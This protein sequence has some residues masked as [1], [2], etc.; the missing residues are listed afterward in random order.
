MT[1]Y[2]CTNLQISKFNLLDSRKSFPS[3]H[4]SMSVFQAIFTA[5]YLQIR[6]SRYTTSTTVLFFQFLAICWGVFCPISRITDYRH[7]WWDALTGSVLGVIFAA[8]TVSLL[9]KFVSD[10][11]L[12]M[13]AVFCSLRSAKLSRET[14]ST[15]R[16]D[17]ARRCT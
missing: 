17:Q 6:F 9:I 16:I 15:W 4:S 13:T 12:L 8:L 5:W 1:E 7:H 3:G 10:L 11:I 2:T 14:S